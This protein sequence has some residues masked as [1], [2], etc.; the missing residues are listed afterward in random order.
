MKVYTYVHVFT[1]EDQTIKVCETLGDFLLC[2]NHYFCCKMLRLFKLSGKMEKMDKRE[3][4]G[5]SPGLSLRETAV[6]IHAAEGKA[7]QDIS[8]VLGISERTV[9][10]HLERVYK[11]LG[12]ESRTAAVIFFFNTLILHENVA[13]PTRR[14]IFDARTLHGP[15]IALISPYR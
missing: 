13:F 11:K 9:E 15:T 1:K 3:K 14:R 5:R 12:V 8:R 4:K 2:V 10:K 6:L 7:N